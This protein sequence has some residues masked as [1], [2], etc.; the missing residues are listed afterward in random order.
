MLKR[1]KA[2]KACSHN[3]YFFFSVIANDYIR[4]NTDKLSRIYPGALR[5]DSSNYNPVPLWNVGCQIGKDMNLD[6]H[7]TSDT[8]EIWIYMF[9]TRVEVDVNVTSVK[10]IL[11]LLPLVALNFQT[12]CT[13]M[14]LNQ[15]LFLQNG[16]SGY[17]L[18]PSYL[19][20]RDTEFDPITLTKGPWLKRKTLHVMA[21]GSETP[22][23]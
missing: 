19:R 10:L 8:D 13:E 3:N 6:T 20:D 16:Q 22:L 5:T 4:H 17:V 2:T 23:F 21:S 11:S 15:G 12:P 14:D 18:K 1:E 7:H 9:L